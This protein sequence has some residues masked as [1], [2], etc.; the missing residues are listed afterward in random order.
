MLTKELVLILCLVIGDRIVGPGIVSS[1]SLG[2]RF[3]HQHHQVV[4][5]GLDWRGNNAQKGAVIGPPCSEK[6]LEK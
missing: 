3:R 1:T 4:L 6:I 5:N 2:A